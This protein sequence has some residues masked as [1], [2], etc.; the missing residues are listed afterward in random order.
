MPQKISSKHCKNCSRQ[1]P[2]F[3]Y[4][5]DDE[6]DLIDK[7]RYEVLYNPGET[8][9]KQGA[10]STHAISFTLGM[11]KIYIEGDSGKN[12]ILRI[13]KPVEFIAGPG[14]YI[15]NRHHY[16]ITALEK[17]SVCVIDNGVFK[18]IM[19]NNGDFSEA[20]IKMINKNY[21]SALSRLSNQIQKQSKGKVAESILYLSNDIYMVNPF[22]LS[23]SLHELSELSGVSKESVSKILKEFIDDGIIRINKKQVE[24]INNDF[25]NEISRKG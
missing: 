5:T 10:P 22:S 15:E 24:I 17:S 9:F 13:I 16:S 18:Q 19:K 21:V 20:Y 25:L 12:V 8:I 4:L 14:L 23:I 3:K 11:A 7:S 2:F 1:A 6:L